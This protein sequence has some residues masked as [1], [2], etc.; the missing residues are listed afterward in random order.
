[1]VRRIMPGD[2]TDNRPR[3]LHVTGR[4]AES[5]GEVESKLEAAGLQVESCEDVYRALA[6]IMRSLAAR[7]A[8]VVVCLDGMGGKELDF[9]RLISRFD[10]SLRVYVYGGSR[11]ESRFTDA[12]VESF[13]PAPP[14]PLLPDPDRVPSGTSRVRKEA[15]PAEPTT[16]PTAESERTREDVEKEPAVEEI[17][18]AAPPHR[19]PAT[20]IVPAARDQIDEQGRDVP[21]APVRV[22]WLRYDDRP[23]R[24]PP[25]APEAEAHEPAPDSED[26]PTAHL[27]SCEPLLT[28]AELEALMGDDDIASIA[29]PDPRR[30]D[31]ER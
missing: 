19:E 1:M 25:P 24:Q 15:I 30:E 12:A 6:R 28:R 13:K 3:V 26:H 31:E 2:A 17:R 14:R 9:F 21:S 8:A 4:G 22:P 27:D 29:P 5:R 11:P 23:V 20:P 18:P 16:I 10:S 7:P